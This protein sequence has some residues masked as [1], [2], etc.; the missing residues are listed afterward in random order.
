MDNLSDLIAELGVEFERTGRMRISSKDARRLKLTAPKKRK[1]KAER[2]TAKQDVESQRRLFV[3]ACKAHGL[4]EPVPEFAF[5]ES[6]GRRWRFDWFWGVIPIQCSAS[7]SRGVALEIDGGSWTGG[8]HTT[9]KGFQEDQQKRNT[10]TAMGIWVFHCTPQDVE[11][12]AVFTMLREVL[13][14]S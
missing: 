4:P 11:S 8:R 5:A 2:A 7:V 12:G 3:E 9:G 13:G 10:A 14:I 6:I 1:T